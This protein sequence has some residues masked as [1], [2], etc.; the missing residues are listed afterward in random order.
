VRS[1]RLCLPARSALRGADAE[2]PTS[3]I[4]LSGRFS[5]TGNGIDASP[6]HVGVSSLPAFTWEATDDLLTSV[7]TYGLVDVGRRNLPMRGFRRGRPY[8]CCSSGSAA[9][10]GRGTGACSRASGAR[11]VQWVRGD[12]RSGR[13]CNRST[14]K[15]ARDELAIYARDTCRHQSDGTAGGEV[16]FT[17]VVPTVSGERPLMRSRRMW[18]WQHQ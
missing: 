7:R 6:L 16:G 13:D 5:G 10:T 18:L 3:R 12:H 14:R 15:H 11:A 4:P 8:E 2:E 9:S 17:S 1:G